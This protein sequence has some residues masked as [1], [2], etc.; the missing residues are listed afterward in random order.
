MVLVKVVLPKGHLWDDTKHLLDEAG[1]NPNLKDPRSYLVKTN[2]PE[3]QMRIHRAQNI[4]LLVEEGK[5]D[6]GIT[7]L[8]WVTE[9]KADV[10]LL[11]DLGFGGVD[12]VAAIPQR[13]GLRLSEEASQDE[14]FK[15]FLQAIKV[16]GKKRVIVAS[17]YENLTTRLCE[18][19]F[20]G[21]PYRFI[22]SYG[23]TETFI[24]VAD[25]IVDCTET[26]RT[27]RENGWEVVHKLF[28]STARLIACKECLKDKTKKAK[29]DG[30]M[31]II[32]GAQMAKGLKLLKMNVPESA[33][34]EIIGVL[35][36]M[37]SPTISQLYGSNGGYAVEVAVRDEQIVQL[38]PV[39]KRKGATD[40]I[41][42]DIKKAIH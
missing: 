11:M 27:L 42:L 6:L 8:D 37:K 29:I 26:G 31:T 17:E 23:A 15:R 20:S 41:E 33:F 34:E 5:Y 30:F 19:M 1:Y 9:P 2:D 24:D 13:Y 10:E 21:F 28:G 36:S 4:G 40:I 3:I 32:N 39:L 35:P 12:V 14:V 18:D 38:I 22:R 25:M 7:G 16:E